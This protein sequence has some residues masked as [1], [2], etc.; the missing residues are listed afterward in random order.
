[1][2]RKI[3]MAEIAALSVDERI[4]LAQAIWDSIAAEAHAPVLSDEQRQELRRRAA[5][6]ESDPQSGI[7][8]EQIE[9]DALARWKQ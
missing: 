3:D 9:A 8:W 1:M 5:E 6:D 2:V 4:A 7:P